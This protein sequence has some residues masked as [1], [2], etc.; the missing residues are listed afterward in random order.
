MK[1]SLV[2][3]SL[4]R[5][6]SLVCGAVAVRCL[7]D[8]GCDPPIDRAR[9]RRRGSLPPASRRSPQPPTGFDVETRYCPFRSPPA[10]LL[11]KSRRYAGGDVEAVLKVSFPPPLSPLPSPLIPPFLPAPCC[12]CHFRSP[13]ALCPSVRRWRVRPNGK[14][15]KGAGAVSGGN[16]ES[17]L[18]E[19]GG[20]DVQ[21]VAPPIVVLIESRRARY[22]ERRN[23]QENGLLCRGGAGGL[24]GVK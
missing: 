16:G 18:T 11:C 4:P 21:N 6:L 8:R 10:D 12:C 2:G 15:G 5:L 23:S 17:K 7:A 1:W 24:K 19:R 20:R 13:T 22:G 14:N 9:R 3:V